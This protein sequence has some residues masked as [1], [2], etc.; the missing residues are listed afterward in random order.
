M[1]VWG[2]LVASMTLASGLLLMLEP[3]PLAPTGGMALAAVDSS[4]DGLAQIF[5]TRPTAIPGRWQ[6]IVIHHSGQ[7][8]G[9]AQSIGELHQAHGFGGLGYHF[10]ITNGDGGE[11]G[12]I[13]VGYR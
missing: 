2:T 6:R 9:N 13:Q 12:M 11:N 3:K 1:I 7:A 4:S 5:N 10:V 8:M